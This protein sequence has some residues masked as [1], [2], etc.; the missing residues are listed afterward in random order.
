M[1]QPVGWSNKLVVSNVTGTNTDSPTI[2]STDS[3]FVDLAYT[4]TGSASTPGDFHVDLYLDGTFLRQ[5]DHETVFQPG[6]TRAVQDVAIGSVPGG[7]HTLQVVIDADGQ[8]DELNKA[9][10]TFSRTFSVIGVR[11]ESG[12]FHAGGRVGADP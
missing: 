1:S 7:V 3:L 11:T 12:A 6:A 5:I 2:F 10:N 9:D 8:V 4:N